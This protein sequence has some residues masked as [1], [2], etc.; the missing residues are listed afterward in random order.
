MLSFS[1]CD[2]NKAVLDKLSKMLESLF[3]KYNLDA[4][5]TR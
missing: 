5:I 2:D 1:I 4:E 3:I